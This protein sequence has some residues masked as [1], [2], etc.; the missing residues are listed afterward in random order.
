MSTW[1]FK[2]MPGIDLKVI[3]YQLNV[4]LSYKL[5]HYKRLHF[6]LKK[7]AIEEEVE[8]LFKENFSRKH[9]TEIY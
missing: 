9:I 7:Y 5:V 6:N 2:D 8:K 4:D 3:V 1:S